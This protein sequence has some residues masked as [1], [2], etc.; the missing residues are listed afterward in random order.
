MSGLSDV[1]VDDDYFALAAMLDDDEIIIEEDY[2]VFQG[3]AEG[4]HRAEESS[5][6]DKKRSGKRI[7]CMKKGESWAEYRREIYLW[8]LQT[9]IPEVRVAAS[10]LLSGLQKHY[11]TIVSDALM[12]PPETWT[13]AKEDTY[14]HANP[15]VQQMIRTFSQLERLV[16][17]LDGKFEHLLPRDRMAAYNQLQRFERLGGESIIEAK[18]RLKDVISA[19]RTAGGTPSEQ[20]K[21]SAAYNGLNLNHAQRLSLLNNF[22]IHAHDATFEQ[23]SQTID[24]LFPKHDKPPKKE[25]QPQANWAK[26]KGKGKGGKGKGQGKGWNN[27]GFGNWNQGKGGKGGWNYY[28]YYNGGKGKGYYQNGKGQGYYQNAGKGQGYTPGK[29]KGGK[30][31]AG[32]GKGKGGKAY[33]A[34]VDENDVN[35]DNVEEISWDPD[36]DPEE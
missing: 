11:D 20:E 15:E 13:H 18:D 32:K 27:W 33:I 31:K 29:G 2:F 25:T 17:W 14:D 8:A 35:W 30:G 34:F 9:E 23:M 3:V 7:R 19:F 24:R 10:I 28:G 36:W 1:V 16:S 5:D 26:G 4:K 12:F 21:I 22:A 6:E